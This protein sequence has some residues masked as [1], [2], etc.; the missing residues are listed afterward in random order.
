MKRL[1]KS[2]RHSRSPL[3][4]Q[5]NSGYTLVEALITVLLFSIILGACVMVLLTGTDSWQ[6]NN[7]LVEVQ[8]DLRKA[9]DWMKEDLVEAGT[10]TISG[11]PAD[12]N[13]YYTITFKVASSISGGNIVWSTDTIQ[14]QLSSN[15][16][17]RIQGT[18]TKTLAYNIQSLQ[19]R[20]Q[21]STSNIVEVSLQA[22][23][24][25]PRGALITATKN[26]QVKIRN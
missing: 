2:F 1:I 25:T 3:F 19:F 22:Q 17:Q 13:P 18:Q 9:E 7:T 11:V 4:Y 20:R 14:F 6:V 8:Q 12:G 10:T 16:L 23:K 26:F 24:N 5:E 21:A 15:D